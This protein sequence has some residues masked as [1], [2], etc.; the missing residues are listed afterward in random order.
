MTTKVVPKKRKLR[1]MR[2]T[3]ARRMHESLS[4]TAQLSLHSTIEITELV[5]YKKESN[6]SYTDLFVKATALALTKHP[7]INVSLIDN[8]IHEWPSIN[9]GLAVAVE[10]GLVV[11][12]IENADEI[13][14]NELAEQRKDLVK[15]AHR[16]ELRPE[17]VTSGTF[18][19]SNLG[20]YPIDGFTPILNP[21]QSA[22][23]GIGRIQELP[24]IQNNEIVITPV[25]H[26]S[27]I[28]DHQ[29]IDG[30]PAAKFIE[31]LQSILKHPNRL[32]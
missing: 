20:L 5:Q 22:L 23:L 13:T 32:Q 30:E 9:I 6:H 12:T 7:N 29:V 18:T 1:G 19:I 24:R 4:S 15:R 14:L 10:D 3:I 27:L 21:P 17:E 31:E 26:L 25:V 8:V 2:R 28:V 11:P 16:N